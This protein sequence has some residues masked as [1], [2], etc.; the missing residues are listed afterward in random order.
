MISTHHHLWQPAEDA[1]R[2]LVLLHGTGGNEHS[3]VPLAQKLDPCANVLSPRG[4]VLEHGMPR[5]FRRLAEGVFDMDDLRARS[6][7]LGEW[8]VAAQRA[9]GFDAGGTTIVG[10]SNGANVASAMLLLRPDLA[11]GLLSRLALL[12]PMLVVTPAAAPELRGARVLISAGRADPITPYL[13]AHGAKALGEYLIAC[14][15]EVTD[16]IDDGDHALNH[17]ALGA[18]HRWLHAPLNAPVQ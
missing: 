9:Y 10:Y 11:T 8:L 4:N 3:L 13:G 7:A 5:F 15:A 2:T 6:F 12:R 18:T 1:T 17:V 16:A 14:G